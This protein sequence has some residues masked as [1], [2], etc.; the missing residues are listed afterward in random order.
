MLRP[1]PGDPWGVEQHHWNTGA[2]RKPTIEPRWAKQQTNNLRSQ[3]TKINS[4]MSGSPLSLTP[5]PPAYYYK[6]SLFAWVNFKRC[7]SIQ[8]IVLTQKFEFNRHNCP[9]RTK[10]LTSIS[11]SSGIIAK[12]PRAISVLVSMFKD[13]IRLM[14]IMCVCSNV[15]NS[16][17]VNA[18]Q[19]LH[20]YK[21]L[22]KFS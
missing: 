13:C 11:T 15:S 6:P 8:N 16:A 1:T 10:F 18:D 9:N 22:G 20:P 2:K 14:Q 3:P 5:D 21:A 12:R 4:F 7:Q 19:F 17:D